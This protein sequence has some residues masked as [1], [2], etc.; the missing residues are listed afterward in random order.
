M[1]LR[2]DRLC[3]RT[4][5]ADVSKDRFDPRSCCGR[6]L[7][8]SCL[9]GGRYQRWIQE[10]LAGGYAAIALQNDELV[11]FFD[12]DDSF[13]IKQA[14]VSLDSTRKIE[15]VFELQQLQGTSINSLFHKKSLR[16]LLI[17]MESTR[18]ILNL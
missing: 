12:A 13:A 4:G 14:L 2:K 5:R 15:Y 1:A 8:E 6:N 7:W 9:V 11:P 16:K 17:Y 18:E 10:H 3:C